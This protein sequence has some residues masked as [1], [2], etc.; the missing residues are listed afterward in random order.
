MSSSAGGVAVARWCG[1]V[2]SR[3]RCSGVPRQLASSPAALGRKGGREGH[4]NLD[5]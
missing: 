5:V 3:W 4:A 1:G 2:V